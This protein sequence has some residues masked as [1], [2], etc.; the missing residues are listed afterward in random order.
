[1]A[2]SSPAAAFGN[3][4]RVG[5]WLFLGLLFLGTGLELLTPYAASV[6]HPL[7]ASSPVLGWCYR[8][9]GARGA[10]AVF[11]LVQIPIGLGLLSG[12][13]RP[14]DWPA[15]L[16]AAGAAVTTAITSSFLL[17]APGVIVGRTLL[18]APLL[19]LPVGQFLAKD[20]VLLAAS[21]LLVGE[22]WGGGR[23]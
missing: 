18:N 7:A 8:M 15:R 6:V 10:A 1:L 9:W 2:K 23:R 21:L 20:L 17:T 12:L 4:G 14:G 22:S 13:G 3:L 19:S 16:G 5:L 11:G